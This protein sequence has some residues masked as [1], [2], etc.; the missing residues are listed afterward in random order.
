MR[1][2]FKKNECYAMRRFLAAGAVSFVCFFT[3]TSGVFAQNAASMRQ[4]PSNTRVLTAAEGRSIVQAAWQ[5]DPPDRG[6]TDCSHLVHKIFESAGFGYSYASSFE[7]YAGH[8]N[9]VRVR[10]PRAGDVIAWPGHVG[11]V[12]DPERHTF[13]SLVREGVEELDY[14]SP[15]WAARGR[16]RFL[17]YRVDN[18]DVVSA[19][20]APVKS[21][22]QRSARTPEAI[23]AAS[24]GATSR[25]DANRP[26]IVTA[27]QKSA[28]VYGP[29]ASSNTTSVDEM[30]DTFV[31]PSSV[32][33]GLGDAPP[34]R[35]DVV[36]GISAMGETLGDVLRR[37]D[38]TQMQEP[39]IIVSSF[40]VQKVETKRDRGWAQLL[41]SEDVSI[42]AGKAEVRPRKEKVRW[43]L[44][45]TGSGWEAVA[46]EKRTYV[47][48]DVAVKSLAARLAALS[49][50]AKA[51]QHDDETLHEEA[52][53]AGILNA[54]LAVK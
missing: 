8:D 21:G 37:Q 54:L 38:L 45:R 25:V 10:Y 4:I 1:G 50:S 13:Y 33:V 5:T 26:P 6:E 46:P 51:A 9:F 44:R 35:A 15:Y 23:D 36:G 7:L 53:I 18:A 24:V 41:V 22:K 34:T 32:P 11:I 28:E 31:V 29:P 14:E 20:A 40:S 16:P 48:R 2:G 49:S 19:D 39:V 43:E 47:P 27:S 52:E 12:V 17:R 42:G 30:S 3:A